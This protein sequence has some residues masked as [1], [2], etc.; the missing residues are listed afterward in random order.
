MSPTVQPFIPPSAQSLPATAIAGQLNAA[1]AECHSAVVIAPP[2]AGKST[3]LPLTMLS[4]IPEGRIIMLEPRRI[5]AR[6]VAIR[7]A[8]LLDEP[9]GQTVG[10]QI[11]FDRK[12]SGKTRI[13][14]V[15]EGIL[16]RRMTD[17]P[18]LDGVSCIIFDEFH[19]RSLQTDLAF[20]LARQIR[21]ILRPDLNLVVMSA[22]IDAAPICQAIGGHEI[23]CSGKM[24]PVEIIHSDND[25]AP[26]QIAEM[27]AAAVSRAH[28]EHKGDILAFLPGQAD[29]E[30]CAERLG[31]SLGPTAI[32]PLYGNLPTDRQ[33]A[34]IAPSPSGHRKVVLAT[35]IAETSITIEGV[36]IVIDCGYYRKLV[37]DAAT[38]LSH[39][40][41]VRI[42]RDMARQRAGR[43]GR[44]APG[45][46]YELWTAATDLR[47]NEQR[48]PEIADADLTP[49][50]L[51]IA[52]FGETNI[53]ELP[54]LTPPPD[55]SVREA[56]EELQLLHAISTDGH[57][58]PLGKR[59]AALPC[60]PRIARM[61][62]QGHEPH[63]KALACDVAAILEEKDVMDIN[64]VHASLLLRVTALRDARRNRHVGPWGRIARIAAEYARMVGVDTDNSY[65]GGDEIGELV[66][67]GYPER[68]AMAVGHN[69]DYRLSGGGMVSL[70]SA[71]QLAG[72]Q[73]LAIAALHAGNHERGRAF[74]AAPVNISDINDLTTWVDNITWITHQGGIVAQREQRIGQLV[75][76]SKP[77]TNLDANRLTTIICNAVAKEG[78]GL[79]DWNDDVRTLQ[80]RVA[81]VAKWHPEL[82]LP[83]LTTSH[84]LSQP[85]TWLPFWLN[86]NGHI[87]I[88]AAE[89][90]KIDLTQVLWNILTY[91]QQQTIDRLAPMRIGVASGRQVKVKYRIGTDVPVLSVRLQ[92][93]FGMT[94]TPT[95]NDGRVP[96]LMEL[97]SPGFKPVQLTSD[98]RSFWQST[99]FDVRKELRRRYPKHAWPEDPTKANPRFI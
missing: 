92:E 17:D 72:Y 91:D 61:M 35:P 56:Q 27:V 90:H 6:Q 49:M 40:E 98:L 15:T 97:L 74:L 41:T 38:G 33:Q 94:D 66:A 57:I 47:M 34:A 30:R 62:V 75:V 64:N 18:T 53:M 20:C 69:G 65:V 79:L 55:S 36:R 48:Q 19:E 63:R 23:A 7:M 85:E 14:V 88:T 71:D 46:C 9:V 43:A 12:I 16:S 52:S 39:L 44:V 29:I 77:L 58:T 21:D 51:D 32:C 25:P 42:S 68:I 84:L 86:R 26:S 87:I 24:Y 78:Q 76:Q 5:A 81:L 80:L 10:Y 28:R 2:G 89:L 96:V 59:M 99:Y 8:Q 31:D 54:W 13:E 93:C 60:H 45:L 50:A 22:T 1:L 73:W 82:S 3:L 11:R 67:S 95:V 37:F 4:A 83:D 70:D